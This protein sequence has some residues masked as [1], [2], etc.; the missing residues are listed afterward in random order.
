VNRIIREIIVLWTVLFFAP[1]LYSGWTFEPP[2]DLRGRMAAEEDSSRLARWKARV[3]AWFALTADRVA[4]LQKHE[5]AAWVLIFGALGVLAGRVRRKAADRVRR[6]RI[7]RGLREIEEKRKREEASFEKRTAYSR[8]LI[9]AFKVLGVPFGAHE[10]EVGNA[11]RALARRYH[12]DRFIHESDAR[13][14]E[15]GR[16]MEE[17]NGAYNTLKKRFSREA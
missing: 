4:G 1:P 7:E 16:K 12:P 8:E 13:R 2:R 6:R 5:L 9:H 10:S 14:K 17:V 15:A 11:Y 3:D